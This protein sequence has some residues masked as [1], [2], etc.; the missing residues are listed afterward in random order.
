VAKKNDTDGKELDTLTFNTEELVKP[1]KN[2]VPEGY[3]DKED[4]FKDLRETYEL[5]LQADED[6]RKA[7]LE[8]KKFAAGEQWD[9][10]VL[11]QRQ[12]LPCLVI[13]TVP[14]FTA[15]LVGDWRENKNAVKVI[16]AESGDKTIADIRSDLIRSIETKCRADR[17]FDNAFESMVQCGDASFRVGVQYTNEDVFDQEIVLQSIDD[18]LSVVWDRMSI[19]PTGRDANHCFVDDVMPTKEFKK[20]WPD[21]DPSK[22]SETEKKDL[23][24][25]GWLDQGIVRVTE[26]WRLIERKRLLGMFEDGS[27]HVIEGEKYEELVEKHGNLVRSRL[28]PCRYAQMHLVTGYEILAGPYEWKLNRLPIIRMAGR[29]VSVGDRR[30]RYG[31]VRFMKDAVRLRNFWRSIAAEQLGYAPKAQWIAPESAV[32]GK[33]DTFRKAHLSR[34]PLLVYNDD[35]EAPPQRVEPPQMQMALLNE[36]QVNAQ[37]MKDVT[38][39]HDASLG[40]KSNE[41]SGRAIMARQREGDVASLTYY[42]NGNAAILEAGDV[43]NQLI[44][45]IYDGTRIVRIIGEDESTKLVKINDP[46]DPSSPDLSVGMYDVAITTGASYTT[47]RVEAAQAMMEAIQVYPELM[48][49]AGDLVIKAQDWPGAEELSER[50]R[51]TI[52]PQL[53]SDKEKQEMGDQG[54]NVQQIMQQQALVQEQMQQAMQELQKLQ[55]ENQTLKIK[56]D[57]EA[58]KLEIEEFRAET[59]RL[60]AYAAIA[61]SEADVNLKQLEHEAH[62]TMEQEAAEHEREMAIGNLALQAHD[63]LTS[64]EQTQQQIDNAQAEKDRQAQDR[65]TLTQLKIR[66][67]SGKLNSGEKSKP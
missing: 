62:V 16:P 24:Y 52:P 56:A 39:I 25:S 14:Q 10:V 17:V 29:T 65:D 28:A 9:P 57:I 33:E 27:I 50:I 58:K 53:L 41:T 66:A 44:G 18:C 51:K 54:P 48:Q 40:I 7:A 67:L 19:D 26:H 42:D 12:G 55:Q 43:M 37:D 2:Y 64:Q 13:N 34:D 60:T 1:A 8:D 38:G 31:L 3:D 32:E 35:A 59:E 22:L 11:Q 61:K 63:Q 36:A 46:M 30:V 49:L 6:N 20:N 21:A 4:Y 45:Q 15:Q 47:R 5:D 23:T